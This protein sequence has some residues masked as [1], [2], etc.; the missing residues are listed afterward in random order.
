MAAIG[1][2]LRWKTL[3]RIWRESVDRATRLTSPTAGFLVPNQAVLDRH[4]GL[5]AADARLAGS[6]GWVRVSGMRAAHIWML[7][8]VLACSD[9][10]GVRLER[11]EF[12]DVGALCV[13]TGMAGE[14]L[15]Q[16]VVDGCA[17]GCAKIV[18]SSCAVDAG[19]AEFVVH[20]SITVE[21]RRGP[22]VIC[23]T[24]CVPIGVSCASRQVASG[25]YLFR[26]GGN[27][28]AARLPTD[29]P[30]LLGGGGALPELLC[31]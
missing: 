19:S 26:H 2:S 27:I 17:S 28:S 1:T 5:T 21:E 3:M 31:H 29:V 14:L 18:E 4:V 9:E 23:P 13:R 10:E 20:S 11:S 12:A 24:V 8:S 16:V 6:P 7:L 15:I 30:L 22:T 25:E